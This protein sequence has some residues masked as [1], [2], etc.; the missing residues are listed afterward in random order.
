[1]SPRTAVVVGAL[2]LA[3]VVWYGLT[4]SGTA[5]VVSAVNVVLI[6]TALLVATG[7]AKGGAHHDHASA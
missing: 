5:G 4:R 7:P 6:L 3:P 1:M 2:A